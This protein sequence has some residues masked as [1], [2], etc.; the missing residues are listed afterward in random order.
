MK[1]RRER[2][3]CSFGLLL[4]MWVSAGT[5]AGTLSCSWCPGGC[6]SAYL[7]NFL[8]LLI[9]QPQ[10]SIHCSIKSRMSHFWAC[11]GLAVLFRENWTIF[12]HINKAKISITSDL[13]SFCAT[14]MGTVCLH[15]VKYIVNIYRIRAFDHSYLRLLNVG[16]DRQNS[17]WKFY[18]TVSKWN[19]RFWT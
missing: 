18:Q 10:K 17:V 6:R 19:V 16:R 2:N 4:T 14:S 7:R 9:V 3:G 1:W 12:L 13:I 15:T 11:T 5:T 8:P